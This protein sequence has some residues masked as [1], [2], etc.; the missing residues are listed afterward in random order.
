MKREQRWKER[1][2]AKTPAR[3]SDH[4]RTLLIKRWQDGE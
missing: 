1:S 4:Q 2:G 3:V